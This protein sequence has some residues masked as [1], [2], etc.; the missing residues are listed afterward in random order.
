MKR[1]RIHKVPLSRQAMAILEQARP[2][3]YN[4]PDSLIFRRDDSQSL[5]RAN[6]HGGEFSDYALLR[7]LYQAHEKSGGTIPK[8]TV[9]G[10]RS[11]ASTILNSLHWDKEIIE[12]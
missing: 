1:R 12:M 5:G 4:G 8:I 7:P 2:L 9:H 10:F 3:T 6:T 11:M